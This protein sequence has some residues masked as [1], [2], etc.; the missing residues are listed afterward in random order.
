MCLEYYS[1]AGLSDERRFRF[2]ETQNLG[3]GTAHGIGGV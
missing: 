2:F 1:G 3:N